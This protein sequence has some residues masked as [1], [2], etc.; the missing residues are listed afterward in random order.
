[1]LVKREHTLASNLQFTIYDLPSSM[2]RRFL[3]GSLV[4]GQHHPVYVGTVHLESLSNDATRTAQLDLIFP[5]LEEA[6]QRFFMGDFNFCGMSSE[7]QVQLGGRSDHTDIWPVLHPD[8]PG[9]TMP[10]MSRID[11]ILY[12]AKKG[13][14]KVAEYVTESI[15]LLGTEPLTNAKTHNTIRPSDHFGLLASFKLQ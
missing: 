5:V 8:D 4:F 11:R 6:E 9:Y 10:G 14:L 13:E 15:T 1:M 2:G 12:S 7:N 3:L